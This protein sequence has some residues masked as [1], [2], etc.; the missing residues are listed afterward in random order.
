MRG[1]EVIVLNDGNPNDE[2]ESVCKLFEGKLES[3]QYH[4][5]KRDFTRWRVPGYAIN[6]GAK[7]SKGKILFISCAE[8]YHLDNCVDTLIRVVQNKPKALAIPAGKDDDGSFL[9][10]LNANCSIGDSDYNCLPSLVNIRFP[11]F[12]GMRRSEFF[13]IG[14]YDEEYTGIGFDDNDIV[15]RLQG[16]GCHHVTAGCRVVHL[17][18]PRL[19]LRDPKVLRRLKQN[20]AMFYRKRVSGKLVRNKDKNWGTN[21]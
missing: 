6:Y 3:I 16:A 2:T 17:Y 13:N 18:H 14:G 11:F 5:T 1:T 21:F 4:S 10:K 9:S 19:A 12:M 8:M 20:E 7:Q 15:Q